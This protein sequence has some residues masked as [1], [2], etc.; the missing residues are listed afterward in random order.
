MGGR[1][2]VAFRCCKC[3][4][5]QHLRTSDS[6]AQPSLHA[7]RRNYRVLMAREEDTCS[8]S[9]KHRVPQCT[10]RMANYN[11]LLVELDLIAPT[12]GKRK[13]ATFHKLENKTFL[14]SSCNIF[15]LYFSSFQGFK[16]TQDVV[17]S[18]K[19]LETDSRL[20]HRWEDRQINNRYLRSH[21][22]VMKR[23]RWSA[24]RGG[25][26]RKPEEKA[27]PLLLVEEIFQQ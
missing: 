25:T 2:S 17:S 21:K 19:K 4:I 14:K 15:C 5:G 12:K 22:S 6:L 18:L 3:T 10:G 23:K 20:I 7:E 27:F 26:H 16:D 9:V 1:K 8:I 24:K 11:C 13:Y